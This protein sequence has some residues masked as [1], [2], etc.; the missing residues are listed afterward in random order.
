M[1]I[2]LFGVSTNMYSEKQCYLP[3]RTR[4]RYHGVTM[5]QKKKI[6][7]REQLTDVIEIMHRQVPHRI[8]RTSILGYLRTF[9]EHKGDWMI[10]GISS[11]ISFELDYADNS[12]EFFDGQKSRIATYSTTV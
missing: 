8:L 4:P 9:I 7:A 11:G 12:H 2:N 3:P 6:S 10:A 5:R 1:A